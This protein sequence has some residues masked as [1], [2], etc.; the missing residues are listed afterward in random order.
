[1]HDALSLRRRITERLFPPDQVKTGLASLASCSA[2]APADEQGR[3]QIAVPK[4]HAEAP[5]HNPNAWVSSMTPA[6]ISGAWR[7][8]AVLPLRVEMCYLGWQESLAQFASLVEPEI[9]G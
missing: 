1:M 3:V 9:A 5:D 7:N 2:A 8:R 6:A 4:L